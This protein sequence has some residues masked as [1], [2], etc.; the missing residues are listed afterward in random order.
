MCTYIYIMTSIPN[1]IC[2]YITTSDYEQVLIAITQYD[3][4][5]GT[6]EH[7]LKYVILRVSIISKTSE[8][9]ESN[10]LNRKS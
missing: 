3:T 2:I 4:C 5:I 1:I 6:F 7:K 9:F 8:K 10:F